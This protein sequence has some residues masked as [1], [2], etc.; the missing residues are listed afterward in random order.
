M[1]KVSYALGVSM[2]QNLIGAGV[3]HLDFKVFIDGVKAVYQNK[4]LAIDP[5]EGNKVLAE[6]FNEIKRKQ[7]DELKK[8]REE[9]L[10][11]SKEFL[12]ENA[13]K[14]GIV[15]TPSGLQYKV[16]KEGDGKKPSIHDHVKVNYSGRLISGKEFDSSY[17]R[18]KP[19]SFGLEQVIA[20]W[21][22]GLQLMSVGSEYEF[23]ISPELG[24]G[25]VGVQGHIP[26]NS[27]LI[28]TV[29]LLGID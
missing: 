1:D 20:G 16:I 24:Y 15:V 19:A 21:T 5:E 2:A 4:D 18:G 26:G 25:E 8:D 10:K 17:R 29:E 13:T 9:N 28:F 7:D 11:K 23:Y 6:Y 22:E 12:K 14:D 3:T 27:V